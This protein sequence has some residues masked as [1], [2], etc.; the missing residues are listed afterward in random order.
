MIDTGFSSRP[1]N[2]V[3][4]TLSQILDGSRPILYVVHDEE[5]GLQFL[6]DGDVDEKDI[7]LVA[8]D[9]IIAVDDSVLSVVDILPGCLASRESVSDEWVIGSLSEGDS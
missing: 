4:I 9:Q 6:T 1:R 7:A 3:V 5:D 2:R 8:L